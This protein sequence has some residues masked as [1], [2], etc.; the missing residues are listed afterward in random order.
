M[1]VQLFRQSPK[2]GREGSANDCLYRNGNTPGITL[3]SATMQEAVIRK[4]YKNAGIGFSGTDYVECHGTGTAVGDPIEVDGLA[5]CFA[6]REGT[7]LVIGSV[8]VPCLLSP[9]CHR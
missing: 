8:R 2:Q 4:A 5:S 1:R 9:G 3:P 7:P 6:G